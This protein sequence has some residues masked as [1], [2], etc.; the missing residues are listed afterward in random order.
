MIESEDADLSVG[1]TPSPRRAN[2]A[3]GVVLWVLIRL[4]LVLALVASALGGAIL[5][6]ELRPATHV[7]AARVALPTPLPRPSP[8]TVP[9]PAAPIRALLGPDAGHATPDGAW[10]ASRTATLRIT[11]AGDRAGG[12]LRAEAEVVPA[13][14]P[15]TGTPNIFSAP[16]RVAAH[17][18]IQAPITVTNLTD[19]QRYHWRVRAGVSGGAAS[20]WSGGGVFGV[21]ISAP[22]P[23]ELAAT[24]VTVGGWSSILRPLFRWTDAGGSAPIA[25]FDYALSRAGGADTR[26]LVWQRAHGMVLAL[27]RWQEGAWQVRVRAV[28]LAGNHSRPAIWAFGLTRHAPPT[29]LIASAQ[30]AQNAWSNVDVASVRWSEAPAVAPVRGYQYR[31]EVGAGA[32][33][34]PGTWSFTTTTTLRL[35]DL[36]DGDW[37]VQIRA[38]DQAG[39]TSPVTQWV[40]HLDRAHPLLGDPVLSATSFTPPVERLHVRFGLGKAATLSFSVLAQG[41]AA[42]IFTHT[43]GPQEPGP[44]DLMWDGRLSAK[45]L[46]PGGTYRVVVDAVDRAGNRT[47]IRSGPV[48]VLGKR[49]VVSI[50]RD[51]LWAYQGNTLFLH[52]LVTNGGPDT[53]TLPGIFHVQ[54]KYRGWVMHSPWPKGSPLWYPD[55]PT[56]FALLYNPAGGYFLHD[57]PWRSNFGPG[58]NSVAGTPGG[59][60]TGTHGC[61]NVPYDVMATL[62]DWADV[63]MVID[64]RP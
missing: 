23:P 51:E 6:T 60:Y 8:T 39:N 32:Q 54:G 40:F 50:S 20:P 12:L 42:P 1:Q 63:G 56:S 7:V 53:P 36:Q 48:T 10:L 24:N 41:K 30:P 26:G 52:T 64:I 43:L 13:D 11:L 3:R 37:A 9:T 27:P 4:G 25:Y 19:G 33:V 22:L 49:I 31:A 55:S 21:S 34:A 47:E 38:I 18:A 2:P 16:L 35:P 59:S 5:A 15:F 14:V 57:A 45:H 61:T 29:P 46:V 44:Q 28:D 62:F 58:S 17:D